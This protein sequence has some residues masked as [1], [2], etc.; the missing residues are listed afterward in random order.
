MLRDKN[1]DLTQ[2]LNRYKEEG[3]SKYNNLYKYY[4][5]L[6]NERNTTVNELRAK[7]NIMANQRNITVNTINYC[8]D[9]YRCGYESNYAKVVQLNNNITGLYQ[10]KAALNNLINNKDSGIN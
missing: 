1:Y 10:E 2:E 3:N 5:T 6:V 8:P 4:N 9:K 7:I